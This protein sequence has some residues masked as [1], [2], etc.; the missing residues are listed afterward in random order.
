MDSDTPLPAGSPFEPISFGTTSPEPAPPEPASH[1][2]AVPAP[3]TP[4]SVPRRDILSI[5]FACDGCGQH[6]EAPR[7]L[8]GEIMPCPTCGIPYQIPD[9]KNAPHSFPVKRLTP[10]RR[11]PPPSGPSPQP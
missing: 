10:F 9:V 8:F 1:E 5:K 2:P 6:I 4:R 11:T 3:T 7:D